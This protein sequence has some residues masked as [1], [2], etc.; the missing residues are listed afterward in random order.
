MNGKAGVLEIPIVLPE[1]KECPRCIRR[2]TSSLAELRGVSSTEVDTERSVL[3]LEYD[4]NLVSVDKVKERAHEVGIELRERFRHETFDL[5]GLDCPDCAGKL[6]KGITAMDG[7]VWVTV[8]FASS[9]M[10]VEYEPD[11]ASREQI[12]RRI[13]TLGYGTRQA[14]REG[15]EAPQGLELRGVLTVV[16]GAL[17]VTAAGLSFL[18]GARSP[19]VI[20]L[21]ALAIITGSVY[22]VRGAY[23]SLLTRAL[24]MNVLMTVAVAGAMLI[25]EWS[26]GATVVFLF[27]IGNVLEARAMERTRASIRDLIDLTPPTALVR[28][29]G[30]ENE[31]RTADIRVGDIMIV[32]PGER[33]SMDGTVVSGSSYVNQAPVTGESVPAQKTP[34]D[35]VYAGSINEAGA[36]EVAVTRLAEDNTL[37]RIVHLVEEAQGQK[38][39]SQRLIDRFSRYYT[40]TVIGI[41]VGVAAVPPLVFAAPFAEWFHRALVM[42]VIACP[43]ALVISTPVSIVS[44]IG[45]ASRKGVLV[46]GG[47]YLEELASVSAVAFDKTGTLTSG[48]PE[49]TDVIPIGGGREQVLAVAAAVERRSEHPLGEAIV[50]RAVEEGIYVVSEARDFQA[51][52]G[53]GA[54]AVVGEEELMVGSVQMFEM[55]DGVEMD[56]LRPHVERLHGDG[57]TVVI[58]GSVRGILGLIGFADRLRDESRES[59]RSLRLQGVKPIVMLTGDNAGTASAIAQE[60]EIDEYYAELLPEEKVETI[61]RMGLEGTAVAMVGDGINDAPALATASVG[62]AM[63]TGGSDAALETADIALISDDLAKLPFILR[64]SKKAVRTIRQNV[65]ASLII[66]IVFLAITVVGL[67]NLWL[68]V[69]ADTGTSLLVTAN[70]LRLLRYR[71]DVP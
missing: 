58:V 39:P 26:E 65:A 24:D 62:I 40:P 43:C 18:L 42:L 45:N 2:F 20:G 63:G 50:R 21:Y 31:I 28:H 10:R 15:R 13:E 54:R 51:V 34:G 27:A 36:I 16:S 12:M 66:K 67:T 6:E 19:V 8:N 68:A 23:F 48:V 3:V 71:G 7:V 53:R 9:N 22:L 41:A 47:V 55:I 61:R 1:E 57:K 52:V 32:R 25:G 70:G 5:V 30:M 33:I 64:L 14:V 29:D 17:L 44:A 37:A 59:I 38:A 46:K 4:P 35:T 60:L 11:T 49:V 69:I 56:A